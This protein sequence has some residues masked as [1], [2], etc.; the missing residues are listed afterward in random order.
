M[1]LSVAIFYAVAATVL[2]AALLAMTQRNLYHCALWLVVSLFGVAGVF[3]FLGAEFLAAVQ[4]LIYVGAVT[5]FL[6][7]G[8]MLTRDVMTDRVPRFNRQALSSAVVAILVGACI[9]FAVRS[10]PPGPAADIPA[11]A[12]DLSRLGPELL[13]PEKGFVLAFEL[14]SVLLLAALVGAIVIARKDQENPK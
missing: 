11:G 5:V 3:L 4:V 13:L 10:L 2:G 12:S 7:F 8:I 1:T 6:I 14:V 9:L